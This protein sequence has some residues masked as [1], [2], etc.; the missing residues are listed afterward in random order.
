MAGL[1]V[2][3]PPFFDKGGLFGGVRFAFVLAPPPANAALDIRPALDV[4][5]LAL[6]VV[7]VACFTVAAALAADP[8]FSRP[9]RAAFHTAVA[10]TVAFV[11]GFLA[12]S[13]IETGRGWTDG[14]FLVCLIPVQFPGG[15]FLFFLRLAVIAFLS[16]TVVLSPPAP[17]GSATVKRGAVVLLGASFLVLA[18][19]HL[20]AALR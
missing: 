9:A 2:L 5:T 20:Q 12:F 17:P 19:A 15:Y 11:I 16:L 7:A 1:I 10:L 4:G 8:K 6:Q 14:P 3:F 18:A 13:F